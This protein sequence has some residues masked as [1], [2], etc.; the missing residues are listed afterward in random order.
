MRSTAAWALVLMTGCAPTSAFVARTGQ[1]PNVAPS[2]SGETTQALSSKPE[3]TESTSAPG[4]APHLR[5]KVQ[6]AMPGPFTAPVVAREHSVVRVLLY[7]SIGPSKLRP[8]VKTR[9]FKE[10]L[11]W[12]SAHDIEVIR[13]SQLLDFLDGELLLPR[14]AVVI[15]I[16]DG[17]MNGYSVAYQ[18]LK[19]RGLPFSL[20]IATRTIQEFRR[21]GALSW[22]QIREMVD[23]GL[24]E[25]ASHSVTHRAMTLLP[26]EVAM[27]EL[28]RSRQ[29]VL[30]HLSLTPEAFFYPLGDHDRRI[31]RLTKQSGYR[32]A[33]VA[34]GGPIVVDTPRFW[35]P[36]YDV[37]PDLPMRTF[38]SYFNH[39]IRMLDGGPDAA[40]RE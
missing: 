6:E 36:R 31:R 13:L 19:E 27:G 2:K 32:A 3:R 14:H 10:Q 22:D 34:H 35:I 5:A 25:I 33:F 20:G 24:C 39:G 12:L 17:E 21:R 1:T 30:E 9:T 29:T 4:R 8:S 23:S 16:D 26:D 37:K 11:D 38:R 7:H 40:A 18:V 28:T 15:T